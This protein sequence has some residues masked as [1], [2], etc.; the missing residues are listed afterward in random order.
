MHGRNS[1]LFA[2]LVL[3]ACVSGQ[4]Q[5]A[6]NSGEPRVDISKII[7]VR[8]AGGS[9]VMRLAAAPMPD[10]RVHSLP[11][12]PEAM[13]PRLMNALATVPAVQRAEGRS[14][15]EMVEPAKV[16][17]WAEFMDPEL[18]LRWKT[19]AQQNGFSAALLWRHEEGSKAQKPGGLPESPIA[20]G[21]PW[22]NTSVSTTW[23]NAVS[24]GA[25]RS[26]SG[27]QALREW[28]K[29]PTTDPKANPW[30][31]NLGSYRY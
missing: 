8:Q 21:A 12:H 6:Q 30:L 10:Q 2:Y 11:Q 14:L 25:A 20:R 19:Y 9:E 4:V 13:E 16:R 26:L 29:L 23:R 3:S 31:S 24:E 7:V 1:F 28:L 27:Q 22:I 17:S 5:A 18:A 15:G